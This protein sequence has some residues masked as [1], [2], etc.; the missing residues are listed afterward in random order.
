MHALGLMPPLQSLTFPRAPEMGDEVKLVCQ[1]RSRFVS[2]RPVWSPL[3]PPH[4]EKGPSPP[5]H[6]KITL[7]FSIARRRHATR[8][9]EARKQPRMQ[10]GRC[11]EGDVCTP[12]PK[13][14]SAE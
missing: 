7:R 4:I 12:P 1:Q 14:N 8:G 13:S 2:T 11:L 5:W 10:R 6:S 3:R 9:S